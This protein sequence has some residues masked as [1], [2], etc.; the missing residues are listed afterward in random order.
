M[1][2]SKSV[3]NSCRMTD[4]DKAMLRVYRKLAEAQLEMGDVAAAAATLARAD[5]LTRGLT[6]GHSTRNVQRPMAPGQLKARGQAIA[7]AKASTPLHAAAAQDPRFGSL[8]QWSIAHKFGKSS[9]NSYALGVAP[10]PAEIDRQA[11]RD[12]PN[13]F[14]HWNWPLGIAE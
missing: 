11:R 7:A 5:E 2:V 13:A 12:F 4:D 9:V 6:P 8:R 14:K 3:L 1:R 10:A